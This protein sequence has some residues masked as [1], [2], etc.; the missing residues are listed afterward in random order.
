M[1]KQDDQQR[2][3]WEPPLSLP[4][5][6]APRR[7]GS[8]ADESVTPPRTSQPNPRSGNTP[9]G[10]NSGGQFRRPQLPRFGPKS[11]QQPAID[12]SQSFEAQHAPSRSGGRSREPDRSY[13]EREASAAGSWPAPD[14]DDAD[15]ASQEDEIPA[16]Q[17]DPWSRTWAEWSSTD[18]PLEEYEDEGFSGNWNRAAFGVGPDA[19]TMAS[20]AVQVDPV[21]RKP[22]RALKQFF[23]WAN[24]RFAKS[25][26]PTR[27][28]INALVLMSIL[29]VLFLSGA[30]AGLAAYSD[31]A[32]LKGLA[33]D[34]LAS[35][36]HLGDDLGLSKGGAVQ[37]ITT[38]DQKYFAAQ[39]DLTRA[40]NDFQQLHDRLAHP[41]FILSTAAKLGTV[42]K[43]GNIAT[44]IQS[45]IVLSNVAIYAMQMLET[46]LPNIVSLA[47]ILNSS[48]LAT[49]STTTDNTPLLKPSDL[50]G[51]IQGIQTIQPTLLKMI[52]L[53]EATPPTTLTAGLALAGKGA[54]SN[55]SPFLQLLPNVPNVLKI[56]TQFLS[57][58]DT[59]NLLG[60]GSP[61]PLGVGYLLM[62]LDNTEIRP[63]GGFQGQYA[64]V[65]INGGRIGHISLD[66]VY[67]AL[68]PVS[69]KT[70]TD[71]NYTVYDNLQ[72]NNLEPWYPAQS[73]GWAMRNSGLSPDFPRDAQFALWYLHNENLCL[74]HS[75]YYLD[76]CTCA[77]Q[78]ISAPQTFSTI[79]GSEMC[80][81][82]GDRLPITNSSGAVTGYTNRIPMAG[83]I[84]IQETVIAQ[85]LQITGP[86][87]VGCP[88]NTTVSS[89]TL[90]YLIHYY[91][92]T[93][94]G[95]ATS[96][97]VCPG[98]QLSDSTKRFTAIITQALQ[99]K[100]TS[101]PKTK[102]LAF[103]G[104]LIQD[105]HNKD[106]QIYFTDPVKNQLVD[107]GFDAQYTNLAG[108]YP[109]ATTAENFLRQYQV[110]SEIYQGGAHP[111]QPD[112]SLALNRAD[113]AGWKME[114]YLNVT[115]T[116]Q[117]Q[118]NSD[119][120][121]THNVGIQYAVNTNVNGL[122]SVKLTLDQNGNLTADDQQ[123]IY[124][125]IYNAQFAQ[126]YYE[127]WRLYTDP[128]AVLLGGN[129]RG[130]PSPADFTNASGYFSNQFEL[131]WYVGSDNSLQ[132]NTQVTPMPQLTWVTPGVVKN[133]VYTLHL[134][135][136][137]GAE[138]VDTITVLAP[139]GQK[140]LTFNHPLTQNVV[141]SMKVPGC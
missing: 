86:I 43:I 37:A 124:A 89:S 91:Q 135:P 96:A 46:L 42:P 41:D 122:G 84:T 7:P 18:L 19:G 115:M 40:Q 32:A 78:T 63:V 12:D 131:E 10:G 83:V 120:S 47:N 107:E 139:N 80:F 88:Y 108:I 8:S 92:E 28:A 2:N 129:S 119:L 140:I 118:L 137:S 55:I 53:V 22:D 110:S 73:L 126:Q 60:I 90:Q 65:S 4:S 77:A 29:G 50:Q 57:L 38:T 1:G 15:Y 105:L 68:E 141:L 6:R 138:L 74:L 99:K 136:Q 30:G 31:Y 109:E 103:A 58:K 3:P 125:K 111:N 127:T 116:D 102:L 39:A 112:D 70:S 64:V 98:V 34:A 106:I 54:S 66:D 95:R 133:C 113:T 123:A 72:M 16:H 128:N 134:E 76:F 20:V 114:P 52:A 49:S 71:A 21:L 132:W 48:P 79:K 104:D 75:N 94:A 26:K 100:V 85:L 36:N 81:P 97:T 24:H 11:D 51:L 56:V 67:H 121:A 45:G 35:I 9:P 44:I 61:S 17:R 130:G 87:K 93:T 13:P 14:E 62:T 101:L 27:K 23:R 117:I 25:Y 59:P 82:G 33:S 5:S 69:N